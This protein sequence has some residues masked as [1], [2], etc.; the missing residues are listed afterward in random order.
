MKS[1]FKCENG[2]TAIEY[3]LLAA[4]IA[5]VLIV[6]AFLIGDEVEVIFTDLVAG[7]QQ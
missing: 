7:M 1:F 5:V 6:A 2:A 3:S 4:G